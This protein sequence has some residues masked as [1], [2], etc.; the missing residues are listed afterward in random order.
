MLFERHKKIGIF[1][2]TVG[3]SVAWIDY[4]CYGF[5]ENPFKRIELAQIFWYPT[6]PEELLR[7]IGLSAKSI[8]SVGPS[9][10]QAGNISLL[11][12]W[13]ET[14]PYYRS[15]ESTE[16]FKYKNSAIV[17]AYELLKLIDPKVSQRRKVIPLLSHRAYAKRASRYGGHTDLPEDMLVDPEVPD[18][19]QAQQL[20]PK[21]GALEELAG[22][23]T[24]YT[25]HFFSTNNGEIGLATHAVQPLD[26]IC[27]FFR[28]PEIIAVVRTKSGSNSARLICRGVL[29]TIELLSLLIF[30][31]R[32]Y[33]SSKSLLQC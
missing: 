26:R 23:D 29:D 22:H 18:G 9:I 27:S 20:S 24:S 1:D 6:N 32:F 25:P 14:L 8:S 21:P 7:V 16:V 28:C 5:K 30:I 11:L 19:I 4:I 15:L 17:K 12:S 2:R 33:L 13:I 31:N 3:S 10:E